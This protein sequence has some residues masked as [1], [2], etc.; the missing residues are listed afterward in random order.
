MF[1]NAASFSLYIEEMTRNYRVSHMDAVLKYCEENYLEPDDIKN[2][3]FLFQDGK[4]STLD[5]PNLTS[6]FNEKKSR[7]EE[8]K[9]LPLQT[10]KP[11]IEEIYNAKKEILF[12][13]YAIADQMLI[14]S[15]INKSNSVGKGASSSSSCL[16]T[17]C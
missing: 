13:S 15:L 8:A 11:I 10:S 9:R 6:Y 16:E 2:L 17:G 7:W 1:K 5:I 12:S 4:N 14:N 3:V